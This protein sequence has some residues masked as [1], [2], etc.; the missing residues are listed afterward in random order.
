MEAVA[1]LPQQSRGNAGAHVLSPGLMAG[2][3]LLVA[4]AFAS[5]VMLPLATYS[6]ALACLGLPHVV[7][8]MRYVD[9]RFG[10]RFGSRHLAFLG[11]AIAAILVVR[12]GSL[13]GLWPALERVELA[14]VGALALSIVGVAGLR[15][16]WKLFALIAV[17][18]LGIGVACAPRTTIVV[19]ALLHNFTPLAFVAERLRGRRRTRAL[20]LG[21]LLFF[22]LPVLI[23]SGL[24]QGLL[25]VWPNAAP[26]PFDGLRSQ[27]QVFVPRAWH[28]TSW[29]GRL[30]AAA[31]FT[32]C[33]HYVYVLIVLPSFDRSTSWWGAPGSSRGETLFPWPAPLAATL[34]LV[35]LVPLTFALFRLSFVEARS[36]YGL[37]AAL[38]SWVEVP[39]LFAT[40]ALLVQSK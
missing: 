6:L 31:A 9:A 5:A 22:A 18:G 3:A 34:L 24:P 28:E 29:A 7:S 19:L 16:P 40:P 38:H 14:L 17:A 26:F 1:S 30:F 8:E 23:I 12:L 4:V 13:G 33:L 15:W 39:I 10:T 35:C 11:T 36:W 37:T 27:L 25:G 20:T 21:A 32:Q 2:C